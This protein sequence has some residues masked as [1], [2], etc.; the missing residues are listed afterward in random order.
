MMAAAKNSRYV[1]RL[2]LHSCFFITTF[3]LFAQAN[4]N[5]IIIDPAVNVIDGLNPLYNIQPGDTV[6]LK[7][8]NRNKLLIR[9]FKGTAGRPIL[10]MNKDA[11]VSISTNDYYG[12][13]IINCS[14]I[15]LS[16][17]GSSSFYGIQI[18]KVA[19][20]C[21]IGVGALSSDFEI[22]HVSVENCFTTGIFAKTDPDCSSFTSRDNFTQFNTLI[23]DNYI[24]DIGNEGMYIGS[25]YYLG[26][27]LNCNG[28]DSIVMPPVLDGVKIY[29]NIVKN[30][31]WDGIQISSAIKR[32]QVFNNTVLNDS[33][34]EVQNQM[35]GILMGGGTKCDCNNNFISNGKGDGI[36]NHGLGGN[37]IF[38]NI[39]VNAGRTYLPNDASQMKHGIFVSDVSVI[40]D[41]GLCIFF[42]DIIN[43]KSDG[44][45]FQSVKSKHNLI[46]SNLII[47][48]GNYN[49][50]ELDN[51]SFSGKDAY[52][53][54]PNAIADIQLKNN[55]FSRTITGAGISA[56]DYTILAGSPLI[57]TG[58]ADNNAIDFD[59][60]NHRRPAGGLYDIGA[61]EYDAGIDT[62]LHTFSEK[63]L[64]YPNPAS[65]KLIIKYLSLTAKKLE[66][67][68]FTSVGNRLMQQSNIVIAPGMQQ[69]QIDVSHLAG[70]I[71][72]YSIQDGNEIFSGKLLKF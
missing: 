51:T 16:G 23:H 6:F 11:V 66:V 47:N 56:T 69:L 41:S 9:N 65:G 20:G 68:I 34:A 57:N 50:Y 43:P 59:F 27:T 58:Y 44:I 5:S 28:Q 71:Y 52:V 1:T 40:K 15:R 2:L 29:N 67:N 38:N 25:S 19:A 12:I 35:S 46:A 13:S 31:G 24:A 10:F 39:I 53:M 30:T 33:Q 62:L 21:G 17:Q 42:N 26:M 70:G 55:F 45:R 3:F 18:K 7:A 4:A 32:C 60:R 48:P 36:E 64:L 63:P 8:G 61:M 54:I 14:Y 22:D 49:L 72:L 37:R